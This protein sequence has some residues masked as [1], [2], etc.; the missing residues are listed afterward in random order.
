MLKSKLEIEQKFAL[1]SRLER[2]LI[3]FVITSYSIHYTKLYDPFGAP[4]YP[5]AGNFGSRGKMDKCTFCGGGPE[6]DNSL[7]EFTKS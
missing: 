7:A 4:Q 2:I 1:D 6:E 3:F 5:Q